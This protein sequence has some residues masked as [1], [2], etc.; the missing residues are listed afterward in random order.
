VNG[1]ELG[2]LLNGHAAGKPAHDEDPAKSGVSPDGAQL[3][4]V[5]HALADAEEYRWSYAQ[6]SCEDRNRLDPARRAD[7]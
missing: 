6:A 3:D 2:G 4:T 5:L 1:T 7:F